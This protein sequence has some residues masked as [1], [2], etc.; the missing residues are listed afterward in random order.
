MFVTF[1]FFQFYMSILNLN[2]K[3]FVFVF[4][5]SFWT[6]GL[7]LLNMRGPDSQLHLLRTIRLSMAVTN[8]SIQNDK[9]IHSIYLS[10]GIFGPV[11]YFL[12]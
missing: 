4:F 5:N 1:F 11:S 7:Y 3:L 6:V 10:S 2:L 12:A 9:L 8:S